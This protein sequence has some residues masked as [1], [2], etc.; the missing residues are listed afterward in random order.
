MSWESG[1]SRGTLSEAARTAVRFDMIRRFKLRFAERNL[2]RR[3]KH[4]AGL[5]RRARHAQRK[6]KRAN[7]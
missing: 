1:S 4:A 7:G 2:H 3:V 6:W 5:A